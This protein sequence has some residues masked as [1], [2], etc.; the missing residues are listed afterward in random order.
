MLMAFLVF[1]VGAA[2]LFAGGDW[3]VRGATGFGERAGLK[4]VIAAA[5]IVALGASAPEISVALTATLRGVPSV[6]AATIAGANVANLLLVVGAALLFGP[7][8]TA[9]PG[10]R[11]GALVAVLA[12]ALASLATLFG[13]TNWI[14]AVASLGGAALYVL[15]L[16]REA[17]R[18][19]LDPELSDANQIYAI[20]KAPSA[21][22]ANAGLIVF[23]VVFLAVG[24]HFALA[25]ARTL[26]G[27]NDDQTAGAAWLGAASVLPELGMALAAALRGRT[28][29]ILPAVFGGVVFN[30]LAVGGF[31][32]L[33]APLPLGL[34][35][36]QLDFLVMTAICGLVGLAVLIGKPLPRALGAL[37]LL[38]YGGFLFWVAS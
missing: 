9:T 34:L 28:G 6:A 38:S 21:L 5:T 12:C 7:V 19:T 11:R 26:A 2:L 36:V 37:A 4:P 14:V 30:I 15:L 33:A 24:A 23:G 1:C 8:V 18:E 13:D 31:A 10:A 17:E 16:V 3:L 29:L 25:G 32:A 27:A 20:E 35:V 22:M